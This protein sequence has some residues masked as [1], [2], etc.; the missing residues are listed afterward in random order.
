MTCLLVTL[1]TYLAIYPL[2]RAVLPDSAAIER[3]IGPDSRVIVPRGLTQAQSEKFTDAW[4]AFSSNPPAGSAEEN[5]LVPSYRQLF[6]LIRASAGKPKLTLVLVTPAAPSDYY[7]STLR[8]LVIQA[9]REEQVPVKTVDSPA[10]LLELAAETLQDPKARK[11]GWKVVESDSEEPSEG[12]ASA[13]IDGDPNTYWHTR[14]S[15]GEPK[16]PHQLVIDLGKPEQVAGFRLLPR[17]DGGVNGRIKRFEIFVSVDGKT[18]GTAV[19][20]GQ[21]KDTADVSRVRLAQ[22]VLMRYVKLVALSEQNDGPWTSLA[23]FDVIPSITP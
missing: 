22:P 3:A 7:R 8:P 19:A 5:R 18:W 10:E 16:P 9:A 12:P 1:G 17:Q 23:E 2:G 4:V 6:R 14:Y 20:S 21:L 13:A 15:G 11:S